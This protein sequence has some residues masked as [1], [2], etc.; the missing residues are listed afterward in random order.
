MVFTDADPRYAGRIDHKQGGHTI[1]TME[2]VRA[3]AF[4]AE[5]ADE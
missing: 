3:I 4:Y 5:L 1:V 2:R